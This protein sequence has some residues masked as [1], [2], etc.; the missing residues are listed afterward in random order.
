MLSFLGFCD[1][2]EMLQLATSVVAPQ[3]QVVSSQLGTVQYSGGDLG[4]TLCRSRKLS[5]FTVLL[6]LAL[7]L[8]NSGHF[9]VPT[10]PTSSFQLEENNTLR[11]WQLEILS[12]AGSWERCRLSSLD[13]PLSEIITQ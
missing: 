13:S 6:F 10:V 11:L 7:S 8:V 9:D 5:V 2:S 1:L 12:L 3:S 4:G